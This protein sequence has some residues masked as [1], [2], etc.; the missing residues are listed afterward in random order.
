MKTVSRRGAWLNGLHRAKH[1]AA[2]SA[3]ANIEHR[4]RERV[5]GIVPA[6]EERHTVFRASG[7]TVPK[8]KTKARRA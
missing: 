8:N 1:Y 5:A 4:I 7:N 2:G 3:A 6:I